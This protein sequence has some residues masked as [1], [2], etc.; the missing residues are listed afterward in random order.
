MEIKTSK[1]S[2]EDISMIDRIND[3][4]RVLTDQYMP[5]KLRDAFVRGGERTAVITTQKEYSF[6][7][8]GRDVSRTAAYFLQQGIGTGC[9]VALMFRKSYEQLAAALSVIYSGAAYTPIE[10]DLPKE[11]I[12]ESLATSHAVLLVTDAQ[13]KAKLLEQ[14]G[15]DGIEIIKRIREWTKQR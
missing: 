8:L 5:E 6:H 4:E 11:R 7:E 3:T 2:D 13:N 1:L 15:F 10:Y 9:T 12:A 14:G